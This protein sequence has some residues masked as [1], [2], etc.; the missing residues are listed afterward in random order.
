MSKLFLK[1]E[2]GLEGSPDPSKVYGAL[3][4][5]TESLGL[6][7]WKAPRKNTR[8]KNP[9][10]FDD[11]EWTKSRWG[12]DIDLVSKSLPNQSSKKEVGWLRLQENDRAEEKTARKRNRKSL[13]KI[14]W[15]NN[16]RPTEV[17]AEATRSGGSQTKPPHLPLR[18]N[19]SKYHERSH[20]FVNR[21]SSVGAAS[22]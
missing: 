1:N 12:R 14:P 7:N 18:K 16:S 5:N 2:A 15:E 19:T 4:P 17:L 20:T 8:S 10:F 3:E 22:S 9:Y 11:K 13:V 21:T 6:W